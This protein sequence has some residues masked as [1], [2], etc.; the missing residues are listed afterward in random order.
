MVDAVRDSGPGLTRSELSTSRTSTWGRA[1][2]WSG[3]K[4]GHRQEVVWASGT[5]RLLPRNLG[6]RQQGPLFVTHRRPNVAPAFS[7]LCPDTGGC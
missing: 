3:G 5:A 6:G 4:G 2:L 1:R 7:D